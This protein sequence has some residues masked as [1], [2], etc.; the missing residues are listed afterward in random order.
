[1]RVIT[2]IVLL[3]FIGS[4]S[5]EPSFLGKGSDV[6][7]NADVAGQV[8]LSSGAPIPNS[9]VAVNCAGGSVSANVP[10]DSTG[11]YHVNLTSPS[12]G[13]NR[14]VFGVPDLVASRI[15]VDTVIGF[16]PLGQLHPLQILNLQEPPQPDPGVNAVVRFLN[17]EGGCWTITPDERVHYLPLNLPA[18]FKRDGLRVVVDF[19]ERN[20]Y[21]SVCQV[22]PVVQIRSI[23]AL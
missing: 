5:L 3:P 17:L 4:C 22:G 1:M 7:G 11:R 10:T 20:D 8:I 2:V 12:P 6:A 16:S 13:R 21:G 18:E 14:C 19:E 9:S 23:H 15:R